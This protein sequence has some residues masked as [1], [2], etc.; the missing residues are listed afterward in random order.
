MIVYNLLIHLYGFIICIAAVRNPKAKQWVVGRK[1]WRV[2]LKKAVDKLDTDRRIWFHCASYGE[3]EQGRTLMEALKKKHPQYRIILSFFSPS[4]YE[5]FKD[6]SGADV[7]CYLPTDTQKNAVDFLEIVNPKTVIFIKYEFWL[8]FLFE[9]KNRTVP[10]FLVSAVFKDHHPFFR[11]YG[12]IFRRSL[13]TFDKLFVQDDHSAK[14][15]QRIGITNY[16]VCGDTRFDRVLQIKEQFIPMPFFETYCAGHV[17]LI[18][19]S[20]SPEDEALLISAYLK[21]SDPHLKLIIAPHEVD[22]KSIHHLTQLL[23]KNDIS[24]SLYSDQ[25]PEVSKSVL[26]LNTIGLLSKTYH[27]ANVAYIGGGFESGIHNCLEPAVFLKPTL[28]YG[29]DFHK[30]N[31]VVDLVKIKA[32][33]NVTDATELE[34]A[35]LHYL[36]NWAERD[37]LEK[38]LNL[39]FEKNAGVTK[40]VLKSIH[41]D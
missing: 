39:Y 21:L 25:Q 33:K 16:E 10:T 6:N 41:F 20:T 18:A 2:E 13:L 36:N 22:E 17:V 8:N 28:F 34:I 15:L 38:N 19:G 29:N 4:G 5:A 30:Y 26:I 37:D 1:N 40:K 24:F 32:A 27:Y 31:E 3:F 23:E 9:L 35:I 11:W 7:V 14:L 12:S